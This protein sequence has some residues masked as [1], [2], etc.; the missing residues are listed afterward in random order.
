M[1]KSKEFEKMIANAYGKRERLVLKLERCRSAL[2]K[3]E[4][5]FELKYGISP[6]ACDKETLRIADGVR[7]SDLAFWDYCAIDNKVNEIS[8]LNRR[9]AEIDTAI[10]A[11]RAS[12]SENKETVNIDCD[13]DEDFELGR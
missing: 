8:I 7:K 3:M 4:Q 13:D 1:L 10:A 12:C 5:L 11:L 6:D 2:D 9:I